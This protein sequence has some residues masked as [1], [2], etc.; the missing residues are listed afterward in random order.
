[1]SD[2][3][4]ELETRRRLLVARSEALRA[5]FAADMATL[6][7]SLGGIDRTVSLARRLTSAPVLAAVTGAVWLL[8]RRAG[9]IAWAGRAVLIL[10]LLR[11]VRRLLDRVPPGAPPRPL[12]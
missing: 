5:D 9:S 6:R 8:S 11:R 1:M 10:S 4:A 7:S 2:R 3:I 12:R